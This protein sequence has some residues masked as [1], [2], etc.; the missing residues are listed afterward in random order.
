VGDVDGRTKVLLDALQYARVFG[1]DNQ[2]ERLSIRRVDGDAQPR[3]VVRVWP[4]VAE[5][6]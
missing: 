4:V 6:A 5:A 2:V 1:N 3:V